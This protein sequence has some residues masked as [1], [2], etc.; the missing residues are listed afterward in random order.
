[1]LAQW[2]AVRSSNAEAPHKH[3][4]IVIVM[5]GFTQAIIGILTVLWE[6]PI[7]T[8]LVHQGFAVVLLAAVVA[9]WRGLVGPYAPVTSLEVRE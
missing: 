8:A 2:L 6:V 9:H 5:L 4:T 7:N 1:M 3:R